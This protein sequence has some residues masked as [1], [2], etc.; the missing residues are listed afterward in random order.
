MA[1]VPPP[2]DPELAVALKAINKVMPPGLAPDQI[3]LARQSPALRE[4]ADLDVTM[5]GAFETEDRTVPGPEG[6]PDISLLICRPLTSAAG[7]VPSS[8]TPTAAAW[9]WAPTG[10]ASSCP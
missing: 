10:A 2:F 5:G 6:A 7:R 1:H 8:T 3:G 4:M 9:S